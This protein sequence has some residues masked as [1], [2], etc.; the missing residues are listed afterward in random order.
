MQYLFYLTRW[1]F[2][3]KRRRRRVKCLPIEAITTSSIRTPECEAQ[4]FT[5]PFNDFQ[6]TV[7][8]VLESG[9][10]FRKQS[11]KNPTQKMWMNHETFQDLKI[12]FSRKK[13]EN[14]FFWL[15]LWKSF[16]LKLCYSRCFGRKAS[17][18]DFGKSCFSSSFSTCVR[19]HYWIIVASQVLSTAGSKL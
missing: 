7:N 9:T 16:G 4:K 1:R 12:C 19:G 2:M 14:Q 5:Q 3:R 18:K 15:N 11:V 6:K 13:V 10:W 17:Y 8:G